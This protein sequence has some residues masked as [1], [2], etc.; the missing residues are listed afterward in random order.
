MKHNNKIAYVII[1]PALFF[2]FVFSLWPVVQSATYSLFDF[3]LN[4]QTKSR[5]TFKYQ[6][7]LDL[8]KETNQYLNF[9]LDSEASTAT[10]QETK[11][12]IAAFLEAVNEN[13][14]KVLTQ[15]GEDKLVVI[16]TDNERAQI[17]AYNEWAGNAL[18]DIYAGND[19][20]LA[21]KDD[22][23]AV[24]EGYNTA[25]ISPNFIGFDN[26][27]NA[28]KDK[29]VGIAL[30]NTT[31]FTLFSVAIELVFGI[32]LAMIMNKAMM[33]RGLIR[34]VSLIP[35]AIP[36]VVSALIWLY[37]YNGTSGI[38]AQIFSSIGLINKPTDLL[39]T[40]TAAMG[41]VIISDVWKTTPYMALLILAGLQT[42]SNTLYE[43][44]DVDGANKL[45]QFFKITLP[46][47]KPSILVALLFRTLDAFRVFDLIYVLTGG[48]PGGSTETISIYA[49]KVMF[50]QTRFGYGS[51]LSIL[52]ALCVAAICFFYIKILDVDV[53]SRD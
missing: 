28:L 1:L 6:Y 47:L 29:R 41:A 30:I 11:D 20:G 9:Y 43:A 4:D 5:M 40:N 23:L 18:K 52:I 45:Q 53:T 35:W 16:L 37:L 25:I 17:E 34:S 39:L 13:E 33:G 24:A 38:V 2:I 12:K 46:L 26:Y 22:V 49:Y 8:F 31:L 10:M 7:N 36:T 44:S 50:A 32:M 51:A 27:I 19:E 15:F 21:I 14:Q 3:Q 42:I 48:G